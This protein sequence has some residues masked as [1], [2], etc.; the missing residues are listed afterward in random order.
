MLLWSGTSFLAIS[1][2]FFLA[3]NWN[4]LG[5]YAQFGL[6]E[7]LIIAAVLAYWRLGAD[8]VAGKAALLFAAILMGGLLALVGQTYQ[9]GADTFELFASWA[10]LILPWVLI[11]R[12]AALWV[13]WIAIVNLAITF[14]FWAF[15]GLFGL[16]FNTQVQRLLWVLFAFNT[17]VLGSWEM[18]AKRVAW[19]NER[20]AVR[21]V[22]LASAGFMT[23]L[24][25]HA[26]AAESNGLMVGLV[27]ATWL[28]AMY[29]VYRLTI[30]DVFM[31]AAISL[32]VIVVVT[33]F[34]SRHIGSGDTAGAFLFI[35][36][37]VIGMSAGA[38]MWLKSV[39]TEQQQ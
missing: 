13:V 36:L 15:P 3:F 29:V 25:V 30:Q 11:G 21:L 1:V 24:A 34:L 32:S 38:A 16:G 12:F 18:T 33:R 14:Y 37:A 17:I 5:K 31:L 8:R 7:T 23:S 10:A 6:V 19:L 28:G 22:A 35:S 2:I 9:T 39:A 4:R 27:Y 26:L 20:G